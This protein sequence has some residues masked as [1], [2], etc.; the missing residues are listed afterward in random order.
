VAEDE[1]IA[2]PSHGNTLFTVAGFEDA[3][4]SCVRVEVA[5]DLT[6]PVV[7]LAALAVLKDIS[8]GGPQV[9][10]QRCTRSVPRHLHLRGRRRSGPALRFRSCAAREVRL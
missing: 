10:R 1:T 6:I 9:I 7:S 8:V 4:A 2:W 5:R 3:M